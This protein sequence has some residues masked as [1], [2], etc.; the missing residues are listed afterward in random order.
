MLKLFP[1]DA[2]TI[3]YGQKVEAEV[4]SLPGR[5]FT[6]RVAFIDPQR[7]SEDPHRGCSRGDSE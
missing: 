4:Q 7:R 6:G 2:A 1:E 5:K 3:R